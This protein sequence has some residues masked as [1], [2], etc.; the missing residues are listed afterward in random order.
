MRRYRVVYVGGVFATI[1]L[2]VLCLTGIGIPIALMIVPGYYEIVAIDRD[3]SLDDD[4]E[5]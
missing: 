3:R 1:F 5:T 4:C 2:L